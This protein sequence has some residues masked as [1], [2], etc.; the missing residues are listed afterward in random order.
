MLYDLFEHVKIYFGIE[1]ELST[2]AIKL[3][4][5][6]SDGFVGGLKSKIARP[7]IA[8]EESKIMDKIIHI[9][10]K[11]DKKHGEIGI[12][13]AP[14][15]IEMLMTK[16]EKKGL[17][18]EI[19]N[20]MIVTAGGWKTFSGF[21]IP[22]ETFRKRIY[23]IFGIPKENCRDIYGMVE[24]NALNVSC[25]GHYKHIPHS[26]LYPMVLDQDSEI[27]GFDKYGRFAFLDPLANSYPGFIMT[28]DRV[29]ILERCPVCNRPGPVVCEDISRLSGVQDRGCGAALARM[30]SEE[31]M[32]TKENS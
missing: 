10:E 17:K 15:F 23:D 13:G 26:I 25:E 24:C 12:G 16:I 6:A 30:F 18:F 8:Y 21:E 27:L 22:G 11:T 19:E 32:K 14:F 1:R 9:L 5:G 7:F 2:K 28:G 20:G 4:M 3:L 31:V 29:K